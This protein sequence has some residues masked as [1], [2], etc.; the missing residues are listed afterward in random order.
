MQ[1]KPEFKCFI[2]ESALIMENCGIQKIGSAHVHLKKGG[3]WKFKNCIFMRSNSTSV[4]LIE[5]NS[6]LVDCG[7]KYHQVRVV[8]IEALFPQFLI[9][10]I[11]VNVVSG[12]VI[13]DQ[14][15]KYNLKL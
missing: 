9:C 8:S 13:K 11:T 1:G 15:I 4:V 12:I 6:V 3:N 14:S 10:T 7:F 2:P 5:S